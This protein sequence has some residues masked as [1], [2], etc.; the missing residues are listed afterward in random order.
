MDDD[1]VHE[2]QNEKTEVVETEKDA[3]VPRA[4]M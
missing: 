2:G 1:T 3:D 4:L